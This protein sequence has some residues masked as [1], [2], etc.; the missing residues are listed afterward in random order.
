MTA[1]AEDNKNFEYREGVEL[2]CPVDDA[3]TIYAGAFVCVNAAGYLVDGA[4]E[5]GL[6]FMGLSLEQKDN[7]SGADGD[8]E[9]QI[10]RRGLV[11]ALF[12]TPITQ[13]NVGDNVF[14]VDDQTVDLTGNVTHNIF[15]GIIAEYID[16]THAW[17]DIEPAIRQADVATHIADASAAHAASAVSIADAGF[18]TAQNEAE[19]AFQ[20]IYQSLLS[21]QGI[22]PIPMPFITDAGVVLAA[23]SNASDPLP[24]FCVTAKGLGIRWNDNANPTA[25]GAKIIVPPDAD[26][27]ADMTLNILA[28][29]VGATEGDATKFTVVAYNNDV[30]ALYD[31][32][33]DFGGDTGAMTGDAATKT[34]QHVTLTLALGNLTAYPAAIELTLQP[35]DGTLG[36]DDVIM[37][38]AWVS[39]TKKL[40]AS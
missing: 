2:S 14:L 33:A 8:L 29:K 11:K 15:C 3:D 26:V 37:L 30:A 12:D 7:S 20:E 10:R 19:A 5:T 25:V 18:F 24:G 28:A 21:A 40:L 38:A 36:T 13:A 39:Y 27:T 34:V 6:I 22:I 23:F 1:L 9:C 17:I 16:T 32:D 35:K 4:D 31:A